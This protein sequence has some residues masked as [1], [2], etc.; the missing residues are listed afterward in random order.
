MLF[1]DHK[2]LVLAF[3]KTTL[4]NNKHLSLVSMYVVNILYI[5]GKDILIVDCFSRPVYLVTTD[6]WSTVTGKSQSKMKPNIGKVNVYTLCNVSIPFQMTFI[7]QCHKRPSFKQS[8]I[9][10]TQNLQ[11]QGKLSLTIFGQTE[12]ISHGLKNDSNVRSY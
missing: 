7:L 1:R 3:K 6:L 8:T 9:Y 5:H 10:H 11:L 2:A 4:V 12:N